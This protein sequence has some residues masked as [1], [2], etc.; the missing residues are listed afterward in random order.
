M[1][2]QRAIQGLKPGDAFTFSRTF[3]QSDTE[4]FGDLIADYNPVHYDRRFAQTKGFPDLICHGLL[5]AFPRLPP[6]H[7]WWPHS[8]VTRW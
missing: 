5:V 6:E 2:R 4:S 1:M 8:F 3:S 7:G